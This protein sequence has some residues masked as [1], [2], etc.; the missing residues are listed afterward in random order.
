MGLIRGLP[1]L[2][3]REG[4]SLPP[5]VV[6]ARWLP[7]LTFLCLGPARVASVG[8]KWYVLVVV[9]DFSRFSWVFFMEFKDEAFGFVRDRVL[10]LRNESHKAMRAICGDNGGEFETLGL[11]HPGFLL[12]IP[13]LRTVLWNARTAHLLRW[14]GRCSMSIGLE[15]LLGG[16]GE[17]GFVTLR[18]GF[19]CE[20]SL[21]RP[22]MNF[23]L[24]GSP[25]SSICEH[26]RLPRCFVFEEG[27]AFGQV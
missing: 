8:G 18:T 17:Y 26:L 27:G 9:D 11:E 20:L 4:L 23:G 3:G 7:P 5:T 1:K 12:H 19:S 24:V 6:M 10:R 2:R 14:H 21:G 16:G 25:A 15:A 22:R 13:L